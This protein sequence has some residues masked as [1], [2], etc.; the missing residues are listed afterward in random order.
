MSPDGNWM[1]PPVL[2]SAKSAK[3]DLLISNEQDNTTR[4]SGGTREPSH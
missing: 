2:L 4:G 1:I 3:T